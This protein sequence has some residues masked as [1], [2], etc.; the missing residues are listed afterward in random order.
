MAT[1][2]AVHH[3]QF[4]TVSFTEMQTLAKAVAQ[5]KLFGMKT[6]EEAFVLMAI[7]QAEGRPA[8]L[9]AMDYHIINGRP[10]LKADA[11]LSRFLSSGGRVQWHSYSD[12]LS[13]ATFAHPQ[14]GEVRVNWDMQRAKQAQLGGNGMWAKYPRQML[15]ARVI[16]EG[17]RTVYPGITNGLYTPEE[18]RD[19]EFEDNK[20]VAAIDATFVDVKPETPKP[21]A[22]AV[23]INTSVPHQILLAVQAEGVNEGTVDWVKWIKEI[24]ACLRAAPDITTLEQWI[25][26][27][28][29]N[30]KALLKMC[31]A[32]TPPNKLHGRLIK[33]ITERRAELTAPVDAIEQMLGAN[34]D[35]NHLEAAE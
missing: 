19:I 3:P 2:I 6:P 24:G 10:T 9:A 4:G 16:S 27:N 33:L 29:F 8:A 31:E 22:S 23:K 17:I 18:A 15:R 13:D 35:H 26:L 11:M 20:S 32:T 28:D 5:S 21:A 30:E 34:D 12:T 25:K 7:A 14:G 1:E